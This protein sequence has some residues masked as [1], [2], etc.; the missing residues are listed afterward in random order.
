MKT[1]GV[2]ILVVDMLNEFLSEGG[3]MPFPRGRAIRPFGSCFLTAVTRGSRSSTSTRLIGRTMMTW[4]SRRG[5]S[6]ASPAPG[7]QT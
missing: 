4:N 2:A 6:T 5:E 3:V 7:E 1:A